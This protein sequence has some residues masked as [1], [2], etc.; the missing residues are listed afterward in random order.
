[1][2]FDRSINSLWGVILTKIQ[3]VKGMGVITG[4]IETLRRETILNSD[5]IF[6]RSV[7]R[8]YFTYEYEKEIS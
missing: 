5:L 4:T 1:M 6:A 3:D 7:A 8:F 2:P